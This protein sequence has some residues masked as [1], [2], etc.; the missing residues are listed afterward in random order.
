M[1]IIVSKL[2][3]K[4]L[5]GI[6]IAEILGVLFCFTVWH[7]EDY[8]FLAVMYS[9]LFVIVGT[10]GQILYLTTQ[11]RLFFHVMYE[12]GK[13]TSFFFRQKKCTIDEKSP[14]FYTTTYGMLHPN[15]FENFIIISKEPFEYK[16]VP[17]IRWSKKD[18]KPLY[19][20]YDVKKMIMLPYEENAPYLSKMHEWTCIY[21]S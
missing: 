11:Q 7:T 18:P 16:D 6:V 20:S 2:W 8:I 21:P 10:M 19:N 13:Y 3:R 9:V 12:N 17:I 4:E 14:I 15:R 5:K 1:K